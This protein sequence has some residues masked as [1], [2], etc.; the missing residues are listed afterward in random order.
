MRTTQRGFTLVE[1]MVAAA[2]FAI[3]MVGM[4]N[5]LDTSSKVAQLENELVD[6][7]ENVRFAAY[8][9]MRTARMMGGAELPFAGTNAT[10]DAWIAGGLISNA[11]G[12]VAIPG[13]SNV[14]VIEG[15]DVLTMRGFFEISPFFTDPTAVLSASDGVLINENNKSGEKINNLDLF[16]VDGL[17]GRGVVFMGEGRYCVGEVDSGS[18]IT[19]VGSA[20]RLELKRMEGSPVWDD[21]NTITDYPPMFKVFRVGVLESYTY[22]VSPDHVLRRVRLGGDDVMAEPVAINIGGLQVALGVDDNNNGQIEAGE[23]ISAPA[24]PDV[25]KDKDV[26][27]MRITVLGRTAMSV[28]NWLEPEATFEVEDGTAENVDRSA[29]WRQIQL[30]VNLR[31]FSL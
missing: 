9:I 19:T 31:N 25:L 11:S 22:F 14:N 2:V 30:S 5:L 28:P 27:K 24:G 12:S 23:W 4:L 8:H 26:L 13:F 18:A 3:F 16:S 1:V 29:K 15:S 6:T 7:Q 20:R 10:G 17:Q 21:L